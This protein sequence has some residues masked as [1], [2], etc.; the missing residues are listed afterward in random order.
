[1]MG[2]RNWQLYEKISR[3]R[4]NDIPAAFTTL[5]EAR[6]YLMYNWH[7]IQ[8]RLHSIP[9][10][11]DG[12]YVPKLDRWQRKS[13]IVY[14]K[15]SSALDAYLLNRGGALTVEEEDG[16]R[17]LQAQS[18]VAFTTLAVARNRLY[19]QTRWDE[20][21]PVFENIISLAAEVVQRNV[22]SEMANSF[23]SLHPGLIAPVFAA[24]SGCRDPVIRRKGIA[25][26][27]SS[28]RQ[29]GILNSFFVAKVAERV[30]ELE[31]S[32]WGV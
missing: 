25:V 2:G 7:A 23:F 24:I 18:Y 27:K 16:L 15:W 20:F 30:V 12:K 8:S 10:L 17:I 26:L 22:Q 6:F 21:N 11:D 5:S 9:G 13:V 1:M 19:D 32:G 29:E 28:C 31:E 14:K 3:Y 4:S